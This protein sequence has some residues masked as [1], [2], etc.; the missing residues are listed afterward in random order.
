MISYAT[1]GVKDLN[2]SVQFYS[3]LF[4]GLGAKVLIKM[5]RIVFLGTSN[6]APMLALCVP[7]NKAEPHP[8]NGNMLSFTAASKGQVDELYHKAI[9]LGAS[10]D[11]PP[12]QR[13]PDVFYGAYF[14]DP[15]G[16]KMCFCV[17]G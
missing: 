2:K 13:I 8:G 17:F 14:K 3:E 5:D 9:A 6:K 15:D 10:C 16:N 7:Y 4:A 1:V 11:G 12:G